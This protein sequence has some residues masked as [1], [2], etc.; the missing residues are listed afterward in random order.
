MSYILDALR[1][2]DQQRRLGLVPG[3][4]PLPPTMLA[5]PG[6]ALLPYALLGLAALL[7]VGMALAWLRPWL[8]PAAQL[9]ALAQAASELPLPPAPAARSPAIP[10]A[11][12]SAIPS[13]DASTPIP[14][15]MPPLSRQPAA[16]TE[17]RARASA[18]LV[19]A[20]DPAGK[21]AAEAAA[22]DKSVALVDLPLSIRQQLPPLA[23]A[24]HAYSG[25]ARERLVSINGRMLREGDLLAPDLRLEQITPEGMVFAFRGYRFRRDAQ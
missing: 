10:V 20:D 5:R 3:L 7:V 17:T 12:V 21:Q 2:S 13:R 22:P 11:R 16:R 14:S 19:A 25:T 15:A 18:P 8:Q 1:K 6:P 24:V 9:P 23:V 4:P